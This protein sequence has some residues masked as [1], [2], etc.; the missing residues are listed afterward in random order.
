MQLSDLPERYR[1]QAEEKLGMARLALKNSGGSSFV[2]PKVETAESIKVHGIIRANRNVEEDKGETRRK[3]SRPTLT[4]DQADTIVKTVDV[5]DDGNEVKFVLNVSPAALPTAQQKGA[6]VGKDGRVHFFTKAKVAKAEKALTKAL[7]PYS[8]LT[9]K[10]GDDVAIAVSVVFCFPYPT[11]TP[12]K[13]MIQ[14][15]YHTN[16]SDVDNIFKGFG[17]ALTE[18][19]FWVDDSV[20]ADLHLKKFRVI[21]APRI[22]LRIKNLTPKQSE[23]F[24]G[25]ENK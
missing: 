9:R 12:K 11:S 1:K 14:F 16:R 15:G 13:K 18:A 3:Q 20:I 8:H 2:Q 25:I 19:G 21:D 4:P 6:F 7:K 5:S 17:D 22:G 10:W 23:L 24:D